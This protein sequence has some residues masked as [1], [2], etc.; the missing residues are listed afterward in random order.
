MERTELEKSI[1]ELIVSSLDLEDV[2]PEDIVTEAPLFKEGLGLDSIDSLEL[3]IALK[4]KFKLNIKGDDPAVRKHF[5]S[6]KT[7]AD[8]IEA[9]TPA[10]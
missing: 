6:V 4:R 2:A 9:Q 3:G 10:A 7:L 5:Y 1:K 8:F